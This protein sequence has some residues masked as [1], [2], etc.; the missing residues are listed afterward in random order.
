MD[1]TMVGLRLVHILSG[2]FW[3]G[4]TLTMV[5]FVSRSAQAVGQEAAKFM[6]HFALRS[7]FQQSMA[8]AAV[9]TVLSGYLMYY[10]LFGWVARLNTGPGLA[11]TVGGASG[12]IALLIGLL[13]LSRGTDRM[14]AIASQVAASGG[15]P[16]PEQAAELGALQERQGKGAV[17]ASIFMVIAL[18]GMSLSEYFVL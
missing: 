3:V 9:L 17:A 5:S 18:I 6:Q 16:S 13:V 1:L 12:F 2:V 4:A 8:G 7:G 11:L 15:P 10:R 14:R